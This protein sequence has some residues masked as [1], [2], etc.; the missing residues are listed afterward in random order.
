MSF[1]ISEEAKRR[2]LHSV[3]RLRHLIELDAPI[4]IIANELTGV[5]L[6]KLAQLGSTEAVAGAIGDMFLRYLDLAHGRCRICHRSQVAVNPPED[7]VC[8]QCEAK[9]SEEEV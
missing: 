4:T 1:P 7:N 9:F 6:P 8:E 3:D 2:I 5:F